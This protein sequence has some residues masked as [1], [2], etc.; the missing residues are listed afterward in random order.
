MNSNPAA[1]LWLFC[2]G[3]VTPRT[4]LCVLE[5]IMKWP[6]LRYGATWQEALISRSR[7]RIA[8]RFCKQSSEEAGDVLLMVDHDVQWQH[9][10]LSYIARKSLE[11]KA[12]VGG[13]YP[14][15]VFGKGVTAV[16]DS[17]EDFQVGEDKLVPA[18]YVSGGF[19]AIPRTILRAVADGLPELAAG[20]WPLFMPMTIEVDGGV[21]YLSEDWAFCERTRS[22]GYK[23]LAAAKPHLNHEG[24]YTYRMI[25]AQWRPPTEGE[26]TITLKKN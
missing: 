5:E 22:A 21:N 13:I 16:F 2:Y 9:G 24:Q 20:Y 6:N 11:Y 8:S 10:D 26:V 23:V 15:R 25:D 12:V 17:E 3:G 4:H 18:H 19:M 1:T 7:S 14:M